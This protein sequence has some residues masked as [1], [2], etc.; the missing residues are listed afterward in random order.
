LTVDPARRPGRPRSEA[1]DRAIL[2]AA[3]EVFADAGYEGFT[4][5]E[6]AARAGVGKAT[7]YRRYPC[8]V[9]LVMAAAAC[10]KDETLPTPDTGSVDEDLRAVARGLVRLLT[11]TAA[12]RA[13]AQ[14]VAGVARN[15][16]LRRSHTEFSKLRRATTIAAVTRGIERGELRSDTDPALVTDMVSGPIFYRRLLSGGRLDA[17]YADEL[18]A[19]VLDAFRA[20]PVAAAPAAAR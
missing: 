12:G 7:I 19:R 3:L 15:D 14:M 17:A 4:I 16:E 1:A 13:V 11:N 10:I 9:D 5:E 8:K 20:A 2:D 6:V 18:V